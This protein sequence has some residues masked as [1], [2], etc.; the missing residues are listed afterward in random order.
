MAPF[1]WPVVPPVYCRTA[2]SRAVSTASWSTGPGEAS[3]SSGYGTARA[4]GG[5]GVIRRSRFS[6]AAPSGR[7]SS[8][9]LKEG[10]K[11]ARQTEIT[12]STAVPGRAASSV[13]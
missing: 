5:S 10:R 13:A 6:R 4:P 11:S 3:I 7:S 2:R 8:L 9:R 1:G 12:C